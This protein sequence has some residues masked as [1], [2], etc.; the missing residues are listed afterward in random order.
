MNAA[1][2]RRCAWV[3]KFAVHYA[4]KM[5][6]MPRAFSESLSDP[7]LLAASLW[8]AVVPGAGDTPPG[9]LRAHS[10]GSIAALESGAARSSSF[11]PALSP[12]R[13]MATV[14]PAS[15]GSRAAS[16]AAPE[17]VSR[18]TDTGAPIAREEAPKYSRAADPVSSRQ[19]KPDLPAATA[20]AFR[21][22]HSPF[23][24]PSAA[25]ANPAMGELQD[26]PQPASLDTR[27]PRTDA[28]FPHQIVNVEG[29]AETAR[30]S[31][32]EPHSAEVRREAPAAVQLVRSSQR[33][34]TVLRSNLTAPPGIELE[35]AHGSVE[36]AD[37]EPR[38]AAVAS[39]R[40]IEPWRATLDNRQAEELASPAGVD[41]VLEELERRL[42][43][44][45]LRMYGT[46]GR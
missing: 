28:A 8:A 22:S 34:A 45:Y 4:V 33:L 39:R 27:Q 18:R 44:E 32:R 25:R 6:A 10:A 11:A 38:T 3:G 23:V 15:S 24:N 26:P 14:Y 21:R 30:A 42:Q 37:P 2:R 35:E 1:L 17:E 5:P 31:A 36:Q 41:D 12:A 13:S 9:S 7:S 43:L 19:R 29:A 20:A 16:R 46:S 40:T